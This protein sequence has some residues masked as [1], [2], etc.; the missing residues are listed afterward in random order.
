ME[1][2]PIQS[3]AYGK[4]EMSDTNSTK[5]TLSAALVPIQFMCVCVSL[6]VLYMYCTLLQAYMPEHEHG[7]KYG[8]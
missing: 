3:R 4:E 2:T 8:E 6:C 1:I 7:I 5:H